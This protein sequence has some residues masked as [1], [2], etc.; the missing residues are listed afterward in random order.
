MKITNKNEDKIEISLFGNSSISIGHTKTLVSFSDGIQR[1]LFF[2]AIESFTPKTMEKRL[3][4]AAKKF[5]IGYQFPFEEFDS[6]EAVT[7][8]YE[9]GNS[10]EIFITFYTGEITSP[11]INLNCDLL[12]GGHNE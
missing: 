11:F 8:P 9:K 10:G 5:P 7:R 2:S 1:N 6:I 4:E 3:E 12:G